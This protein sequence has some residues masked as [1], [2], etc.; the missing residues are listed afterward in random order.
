MTQKERYSR[1]EQ[2]GYGPN[3]MKKIKIPPTT[4]APVVQSGSLM[5]LVLC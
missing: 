1:L 5:H 4:P 2:Y 3:V